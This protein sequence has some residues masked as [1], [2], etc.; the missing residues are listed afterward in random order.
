MSRKAIITK[1][2]I[3]ECAFKIAR[4]KGKDAITIREI[5]Y[6]LNISTAPIYTQYN[7]FYGIMKDLT[8]FINNKIVEYTSQVRS[9]NSFLDIGIGYLDFVY[10]N[11]LIF[12][13][14]FLTMDQNIIGYDSNIELYLDQMKKN[15]TISVLDDSQIEII[16]SDMSIY[17]YGLS[18]VICANQNNIHPFEYYTKLLSEAGNRLISYHLYSSGKFEIALEKAI[19]ANNQ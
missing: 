5:G 10:N 15:P 7:S 11:K 8:I 17:L 2:Q 14:F 1:K 6:A 13:D 3:I 19:S 4:N 12:N 9:N 18:T 16:L